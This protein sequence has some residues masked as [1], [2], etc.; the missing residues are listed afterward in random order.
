MVLVD[1]SVWIEAT[2][3]TGD[4][5][6]K[7]ALECLLDEYEAVL[8]TPVRLEVLGGVRKESRREYDEYF[9][10]LPYVAA[11]EEDWTKA[12][13]LG[14][15]M[16]DR[17]ARVPWFDLLIA[18]ISIR[19]GCRVYTI[20]GHFETMEKMIGV[21]RYRAGYGGSFNPDF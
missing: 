13:D 19:L 5:G 10:I 20:D 9:S 6:V 18:T 1:S 4:I 3:K 21:R 11:R 2:R 15:S 14:W 17:G 8:C 16:A 7:V 12:R